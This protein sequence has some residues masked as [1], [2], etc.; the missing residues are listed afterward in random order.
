MLSSHK[1]KSL[2]ISALILNLAVLLH[3]CYKQKEAS[4][5]QNNKLGDSALVNSSS[6]KEQQAERLVLNKE[7]ILIIKNKI[8]SIYNIYSASIEKI[9]SKP[10]KNAF[11]KPFDLYKMDEVEL[12]NSTPTYKKF[13]EINPCAG[14]SCF[15]NVYSDASIKD[16]R[17]MSKYFYFLDLSVLLKYTR[18]HKELNRVSLIINGDSRE[19][20]INKFGKPVYQNSDLMVYPAIDITNQD[21]NSKLHYPVLA[22]FMKNNNLYAIRIYLKYIC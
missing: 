3:S 8:D 1:I 11:D 5:N 4:K 6:P 20:I 21:N 7:N 22:L 14:D 2:L 15:L 10:L 9:F 18:H 12:F 16:D 19:S 17:G 13:N